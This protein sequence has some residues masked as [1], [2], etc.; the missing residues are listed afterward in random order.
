MSRVRVEL[1]SDLPPKLSP[2]YARQGKAGLEE[3]GPWDF[4]GGPVVKNLQSN[5]EDMDAIPGQGTK[6]PHAVG[7]L[8]PRA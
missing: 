6:P 2:W 3:R 4:P 5:T 7:Q 1:I 8:S